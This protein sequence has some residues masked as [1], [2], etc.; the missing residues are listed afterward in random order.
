MR[1]AEFFS[2]CGS[3]GQMVTL[4]RIT[5]QGQN[6]RTT[7]VRCYAIVGIGGAQVLVGSTQQSADRI[8]MTSSEIDAAGWPKPPR[9]GDQVIY[10]DGQTVVVLQGRAKSYP[11][12]DGLLYDLQGIG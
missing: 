7:D 6:R 1:V 8:I 9:H 12:E 11:L 4:R 10:A 5:G 3:P 2:A